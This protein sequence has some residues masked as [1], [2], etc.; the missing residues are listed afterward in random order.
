MN[1]GVLRR[2]MITKGYHGIPRPILRKVKEKLSIPEWPTKLYCYASGIESLKKTGQYPI[3][4]T[5]G[6]VTLIK[7][8][9]IPPNLRKK[10]KNESTGK[11]D[12]T[13]RSIMVSTAS[14]NDKML[15]NKYKPDVAEAVRKFKKAHPITLFASKQVYK[16]KYREQITTYI[17]QQEPLTTLE[18]IDI[19]DTYINQDVM[20]QHRWEHNLFYD[21]ET[22]TNSF[23]KLSALLAFM[24]KDEPSKEGVLKYIEKKGKEIYGKGFTLEKIKNS[25]QKSDYTVTTIS[26]KFI[27]SSLWSYNF[28]LLGIFAGAVITAYYGIYNGTQV[29]FSNSFQAPL[30]II[31]IVLF[32]MSALLQALKLGI[33]FYCCLYGVDNNMEI[34]IAQNTDE[35]I[36][37]TN[38]T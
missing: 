34:P 7:V 11:L 31:G 18:A 13:I 8:N 5:P 36:Q 9:D 22:G 23:N 37:I 19:F 15:L 17:L 29:G 35:K 24:V 38:T 10:L 20:T 26:D 14:K 4:N 30:A 12:E 32:T 27:A 28:P 25:I 33:N 21:F 1:D 6:Q 16:K 2:I 3:T